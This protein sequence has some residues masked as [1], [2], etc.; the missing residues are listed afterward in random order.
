MN[1]P[2][3]NKY[4]SFYYWF[5]YSL[6]KNGWWILLEVFM[7]VFIGSYSFSLIFN[8]DVIQIWYNLFV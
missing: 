6:M 3:H 4:V 1:T 2:Y 5:S 7:Y 8:A